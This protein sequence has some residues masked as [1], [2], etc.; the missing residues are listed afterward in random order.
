MLEKSSPLIQV[1]VGGQPMKLL[2]RFRQLTPEYESD[3]LRIWGQLLKPGMT[4]WDVGANIGVYT[5]V[6]G[7]AVGG[8]G[9]VVCW[10]PAPDSFAATLSH[11]EA[12]GLSATC[13]AIQAAV[14]AKA[15]GTIRFTVLAGEGTNPMNRI[16]ADSQGAGID[17]PVT[18]LDAAAA[19][20]QPPCLMKMDIEGAE[21]DA[22]LGASTLLRDVRPIILLAVHPMFLP[23]FNHTSEELATIFQEHDYVALDMSGNQIEQFEYNEYLLVP[24]DRA[25]TIQSEVDWN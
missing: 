2:V 11:I 10:E 4:V 24:S 3:T 25:E 19:N 16:S 15:Q 13:T 9:R 17:V 22:L 14:S 21:V 5:I 1:R 7:R 23:E 20:A 18:S 8:T 6:S 12:N